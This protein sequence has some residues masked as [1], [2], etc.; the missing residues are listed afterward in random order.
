MPRTGRAVEAGS[1]CHVL[2]RGNGRMRLLHKPGDYRAF[3]HVLTQGL[4]RYPVDLLT[5][6]L[7]PNHWHLVL[8]PKTDTALARFMG[9]IGVKNVRRHHQ[10]YHHQAG[11]H[12]YQG[13][14]KSFPVQDDRHFLTLCRY[15]EGNAVRARLARRAERW[16]FGALAQRLERGADPPLSAWPV[17]R[18]AQWRGLVNAGLERADLAGLRRSVAR[19]RPWG[20]EAWVRAAAARLGLG[21]TLRGPGRPAKKP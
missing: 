9:W 6:C 19:G 4:E 13:R 21:F 8:I 11:G 15:V 3:L 14:F 12:L 20:E 2:N 17:D 18:P 10:H 16:P 1:I 7:M 5:Y